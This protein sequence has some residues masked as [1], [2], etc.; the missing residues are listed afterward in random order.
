MQ[1][2]PIE[3]AES[4]QITVKKLYEQYFG[5][6]ANGFLT[7]KV[8]QYVISDG[9]EMDMIE[10]AFKI[11]RESGKDFTY[12]NGILRNWAQRGIKTVEQAKEEQSQR[13][14]EKP[15]GV[16]QCEYQAVTR[17]TREPTNQFSHLRSSD[18][19]PPDSS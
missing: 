1:N 12:S 7:D 19:K 16:N 11:S 14:E 10:L 6:L 13:K 2:L 18:W 3:E 4:P 17:A 9:M 5:M 15:S 8:A